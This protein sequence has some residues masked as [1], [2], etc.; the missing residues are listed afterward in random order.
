MS[1]FTCALLKSIYVIEGWRRKRQGSVQPWDVLFIELD[2]AVYLYG[3][4]RKQERLLDARVIRSVAHH[5]YN[6][7]GA[8][9]LLAM[10]QIM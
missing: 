10:I 3:R 4:I 1:N 9:A 5:V 2:G 7:K 8:G 6:M